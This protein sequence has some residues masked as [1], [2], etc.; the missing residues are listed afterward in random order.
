MNLKIVMTNGINNLIE[1]GYIYSTD[2]DFILLKFISN[3]WG[4]LCNEDKKFQNELLK[5]P[6]SK[7]EDRFTGV[8]LI[9]DIKVWIISEYDYSIKSLIMTILLPE[10][11]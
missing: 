4:D 2:L 3:D 1:D 9:N 8:Y 7:Y 11:Y 6:N 5:N 10:E